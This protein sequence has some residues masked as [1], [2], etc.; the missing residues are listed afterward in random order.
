MGCHCQWEP[1]PAAIACWANFTRKKV[2]YSSRTEIQRKSRLEKHHSSFLWQDEIKM[3]AL[4]YMVEI[5]AVFVG[6]EFCFPCALTQSL[7]MNNT[8]L[9]WIVPAQTKQRENGRGLLVLLFIT[10]KKTLNKPKI[11][12]TFGLIWTDDSRITGSGGQYMGH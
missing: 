2:C 11:D 9:Q 8:L 10:L 12:S 3:K 1:A 5:Q 7:N 4:Y 6:D